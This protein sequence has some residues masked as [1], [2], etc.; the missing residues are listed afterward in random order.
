M[1][2]NLLMSQAGILR[3]SENGAITNLNKALIRNVLMSSGG[4]FLY[5]LLRKI[6]NIFGLDAS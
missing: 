3:S 4:Q 5:W 2:S 6:T 1:S